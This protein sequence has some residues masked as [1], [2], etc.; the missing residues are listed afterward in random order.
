[1][2]LN[3]GEVTE[4]VT[5]TTTNYDPWNTT[6]DAVTNKT[7]VGKARTSSGEGSK[8]PDDWHVTSQDN[9][10]RTML[11]EELFRFGEAI[12]IN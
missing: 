10:W 8:G 5:R 4:E 6:D 12:F 9:G 3:E 1:M 11:F 7:V 2:G